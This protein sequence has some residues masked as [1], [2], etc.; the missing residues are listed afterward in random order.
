MNGFFQLQR[1][2]FVHPLWTEERDYSRAEAFLDLLQLAAFT[3]TR[4]IVKGSIVHLEPGQLCGSIRYLAGRWNWSTKRVRTYLDLL[5]AEGMVARLKAQGGTI[6][7][8]CNYKRYASEGMPKGTPEGKGKEADGHSE[9][10]PGA[11]IEEGRERKEQGRTVRRP[12]LAEAL[13]A[14][15]TTGMREDLAKHWWETREASGWIKGSTGGTTPVG[16]NWRA[17][18]SCSKRWAEE[19]LAKSGGNRPTGTVAKMARL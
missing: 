11:Q 7:T 13:E 3:H 17:D 12:T 14:A 19:S 8:L 1:K 10:T 5:E 9:G 16:Q 2:F 18:M 15:K 4:R 6:L